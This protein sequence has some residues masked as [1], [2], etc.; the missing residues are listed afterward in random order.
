M[1]ARRSSGRADTICPIRPC[2]MMEA[3]TS[4]F[5]DARAEEDVVHV[6]EPRLDAV[7]GAGLA[8]PEQ[9]P[10]DRELGEALVLGRQLARSVVLEKSTSSAIES[11][12]FDSEPLK[13]TSSIEQPCR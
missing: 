5:P 3:I 12:G 6:E 4:A 7:P 11:E 8:G 13:I 10:A 1:I 2:S 9:A